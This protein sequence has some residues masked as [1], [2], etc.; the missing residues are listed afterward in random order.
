MESV[1]K[2]FGA[3]SWHSPIS[4]IG[5]KDALT[6]LK[7]TIQLAIDNEDGYASDDFLETDGEGFSIEVKLYDEG[8]N[9]DKWNDLPNH[10]TDEIA[11]TK[12]EEHWKN[13]YK[14]LRPNRIEKK[15]NKISRD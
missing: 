2:I 5:N 15:I 9:S 10:Y 8:F 14:L 4:I 11:S 7:N 13:L 3:N 12:N 1:V 6:K